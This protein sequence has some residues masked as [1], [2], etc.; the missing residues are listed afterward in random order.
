MKNKELNREFLKSWGECQNTL[1]DLEI[2]T[3][4]IY[5]SF[6]SKPSKENLSLLKKT[7]Q[8]IKSLLKELIQRKKLEIL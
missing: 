3:E 5:C 7:H 6:H 1:K 2:L 4:Q 8:K